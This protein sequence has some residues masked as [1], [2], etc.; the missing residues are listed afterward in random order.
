MCIRDSFSILSFFIQFFT[1]QKVVLVHF[2]SRA[3][4]KSAHPRRENVDPIEMLCSATVSY[5]HLIKNPLS[6]I[7][8]L[9]TTTRF[10]ITKFITPDNIVYTSWHTVFF[11]DFSSLSTIGC[12]HWPY[13]MIDLHY[14]LSFSYCLS[15]SFSCGDYHISS[16]A[17]NVCLWP[18]A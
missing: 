17:Y 12:N 2:A 6:Q 8:P 16:F 4:T 7:E 10:Q 9:E 1:N 14:L 18:W 3:F 5:T 11:C 15:F 13:I